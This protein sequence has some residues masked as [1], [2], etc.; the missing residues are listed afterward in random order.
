MADLTGLWGT[1]FGLVIWAAIFV[2]FIEDLLAYVDD[3][4]RVDLEENMTYYAP[5]SKL[6]PTKQA[7]LLVLWD[8]IGIPHSEKKQVYGPKI[9]LIGFEVDSYAMTVTTSCLDLITSIQ[10]FAQPGQRCSLRDFQRLAGWMNWAL[11]VYP[12]LKPGLS[13]M[14]SKMSKK[15]EAFR[16]IWVSVSLCRELHWFANHLRMSDGIFILDSSEWDVASSD[17]I[18]YC[19]TCPMGITFWSLQYLCGFQ[20]LV[21]SGSDYDIWYLEALAIV[22]ALH[23]ILTVLPY[24]PK[25]IVIYT[26]N[27]NTVDIFNSLRTDPN[28]NPLLLTAIDLLISHGVELRVM[29][30]PGEA[31]TVADTLLCFNNASA[32]AY[33]PG[34]QV[35]QFIPP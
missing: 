12:R 30:V 17:C 20:H 1:F 14:Y 28:H 10:I 6:L 21:I 35:N 23:W 25:R 33:V 7:K 32:L 22:S 11:N 27:T 31:N 18:M 34:L 8:V 26:D 24:M 29:H 2:R 19:D 15:T 4:F 16:L 13:V 5:Y 3:S 9:T